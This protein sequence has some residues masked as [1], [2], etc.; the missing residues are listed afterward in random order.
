MNHVIPI[1]DADAPA[2][3]EGFRS[4]TQLAKRL[5][6]TPTHV[7]RLLASR[8]LTPRRLGKSLVFYASTDLDKLRARSFSAIQAKA[9]LLNCGERDQLRSTFAHASAMAAG[10]DAPNS[11]DRAAGAAAGDAEFRR[12]GLAEIGRQLEALE[13]L[14]KT[15]SPM[16]TQ[17]AE[18]IAAMKR[19]SS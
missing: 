4:N 5:L 1:E 3:T 2:G 9:S 18:Q 12:A 10:R 19:I 14:V 16:L 8:E 11:E 17:I 6:V 7:G 15:Q 13:Q